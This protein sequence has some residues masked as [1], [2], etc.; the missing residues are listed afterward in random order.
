MS[1]KYTS[2]IASAKFKI[3]DT[4]WFL[5]LEQPNGY[6]LGEEYDT[7]MFEHPI[8]TFRRTPLKHI[9]RSARELPKMEG[10]AFDNITSLLVSKILIR[11]MVIEGIERSENTGEFIFSDFDQEVSLPEQVLYADRK[12]AQREKTRI[13]KMIRDWVTAQLDTDNEMFSMR[14]RPN[15]H[16]QDRRSGG[17]SRQTRN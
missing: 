15:K 2:I 8:F 16:Q 12:D 7:L 17:R 4:V 9:W 1:E 3:G 14:R 13:L 11:S 10:E 5:G 6:Q